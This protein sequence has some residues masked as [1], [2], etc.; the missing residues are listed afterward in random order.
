[1]WRRILRYEGSETTPSE[2]GPELLEWVVVTLI[3]ILAIF[4]ILQAVGGQFTEILEA[5]Q[6]LL[7]NIF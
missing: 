4:A 3:M 7:A 6:D 2:S 5:A 1:M